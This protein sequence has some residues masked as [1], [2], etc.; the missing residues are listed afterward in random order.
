MLNNIPEEKMI[1]MFIFVLYGIKQFYVQNIFTLV[2]SPTLL[3][4]TEKLLSI[5][6]KLISF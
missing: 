3:T 4:L 2:N 1:F 5:R 6:R